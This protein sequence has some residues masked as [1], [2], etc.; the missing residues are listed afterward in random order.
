MTVNDL[1]DLQRYLVEEEAEKWQDGRIGRREFVH[2][3]TLLV[4]GVAAG[5]VL[6]SLGCDASAPEP[7]ATAPA[8]TS[9][10][11]RASPL[12]AR[13][14]AIMLIAVTQA[15]R[16]STAASRTSRIS[17]C[18]VMQPSTCNMRPIVPEMG[19]SAV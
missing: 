14:R 7:T 19:K 13:P 4:G 12:T 15:K 5:G 18:S 17:C 10:A 1:N 8:A 6:L 2:R 3:V 9:H 16:Q 11:V